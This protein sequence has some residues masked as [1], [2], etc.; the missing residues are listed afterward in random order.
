MIFEIKHLHTQDHENVELDI[1]FKLKEVSEIVNLGFII[2]A[3]VAYYYSQF[4]NM[5]ETMEDIMRDPTN[6]YLMRIR[7]NAEDKTKLNVFLI[8]A[9]NSKKE[10]I[11]GAVENPF[12][13]STLTI[14]PKEHE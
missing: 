3:L 14:V 5:D 1:A 6:S 13:S 11:I 4:N 9:S 10:N 12:K 7:R 8:P 2:D